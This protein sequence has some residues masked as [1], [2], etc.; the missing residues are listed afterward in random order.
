MPL[1]S[2]VFAILACTA[3]PI[4]FGQLDRASLN[5]TVTDSSGAL[6]PEAKVIA[7]QIGTQNTFSTTTN[8]S[9]VY[10]FVGLPIGQYTLMVEMS[11]FETTVTSVVLTMSA[12]VRADLALTPGAIS[13]QVE[14]KSVAPLV[15]ERSSA[16]GVTVQTQTM[17]QLPLAVS[18]SKRTLYGYMLAV[19]GV[20]NSNTNAPVLGAVGRYNMIIVDG[21]SAEY[22]PRGMGVIQRPVSVETLGEFKVVNTVAPEYGLTGG[23]FMTFATKSGT[24]SFH[25]DAYEYFRNDAMDARSFFAKAPAINKQSEFGG[26]LGGPVRIP[27]VYDGHNKTFFFVNFTQFIYHYVTAGTVLTL[28]T[29]AFKKGDFSALPGG[30]YDPGT[31]RPDGA[32]GFTRDPFPQNLIPAS[33]FSPVSAKLQSYFP[34]PTIANQLTN[35][36]VGASGLN[37][38]KE[39][40]YFIRLD[41][42]IWGGR[43]YANYRYSIAPV[44]GSSVMPS[45]FDGSGSK[46]W[47]DGFRV[48]YARNLGPR[49]ISEF[50]FGSDRLGGP[51]TQYSPTNLQGATLIGLTGTQFP[52]TPLTTIAGGYPS[53]IGVLNCLQTQLGTN[54]KFNESIAISAGKHTVKFGGSFYHWYMTWIGTKGGNGQFNFSNL[55]TSLPD[56]PS[57][58]KTG[59]GYASFLLGVVDSATMQSPTTRRSNIPYYGVFIQDEFRIIP[60][61]TLTYG[62][63]YEVQPQFTSPYDNSSQFDPAVPNPGAGGLPG[64]LTFLGTGPGRTGK[65]AFSDSDYLGFSP[66]FGVAYTLGNRTTVR[67]SY[68]LFRGPIAQMTGEMVNRQG[69]LANYGL[70][71]IDGGITPAFNWTNGFPLSRFSAYPVFDPSFA[72]GSYTAFM[73]K[74]NARPPQIQMINFSIQ[75]EVPGKVVL[76]AAYVANLSHHVETASLESINQLNYAQYGSLGNLLNQ[77]INSAAAVAAGVRS[78]FPGF[79][80]TV[81]QALRPYPQYLGINGES[82]KI[83]NS[84]YHALQ[85]KAQKH[86][87]NGVSFLVGYTVSKYISDFDTGA[88]YDSVG[89]QNAYDRRAEKAVTSQDY[90]RS[91]VASYTY[92]LPLGHDKRFLKGNGIVSR[93]LAGGWSISGIQTYH[94]GAPL[95]ITTNG[96]LPASSDLDGTT[97]NNVNLRPNTI[98]GANPRTGL[99]CGNIDPATGLYLN[100]AAF[101]DPPPFTFGNAARRLSY[102]RGCG[103]ANE[104]VSLMKYLPL[105]E[106]RLTARF[107]AE[108]FNIFNRKNFADPTTN[109]DNLNFGRISTAGPARLLQLNMKIIW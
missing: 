99:T 20:N 73:G 93:Y 46:I 75:R 1:R 34:E 103:G 84:T 102:A 18:G 9:G 16:Y 92:E 107:G 10:N 98:V 4:C 38:S 54:L 15:E 61:L 89:P 32:G 48:G 96:R 104:N 57:A 58:G 21:V 51:A 109:F 70:S 43:V 6:V 78:P 19:P 66:R 83:G 26:V 50:N 81:A 39:S 87:S 65:R 24:N 45:I 76:E 31:T 77:N 67:S 52:C 79:S 72:N 36:Y 88:G 42:M 28:P 94:A 44:Q 63:R 74:N 5:G 105:R 47:A 40:N 14:V 30:I 108:A 13:E 41:Q 56:S 69:F 7:I 62:L 8:Q 33:H 23:A 90:P 55:E 11:G 17:E 80:G 101:V 59:F 49:A 91:M 25:G 2:F 71:S 85:F 37:I 27:H 29:D 106:G 22:S 60:K 35:N 12:A 53:D 95:A 100:A 68:G 82:S 97:Y 86:Y 3:A 64:A